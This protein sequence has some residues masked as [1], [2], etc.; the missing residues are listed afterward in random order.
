MKVSIR[1][2][3]SA[4]LIVAACAPAT[5]NAQTT[6][7][8][9]QRVVRSAT[10]SNVAMPHDTTQRRTDR[11]RQ[12]RT[13]AEAL[14]SQPDQSRKAVKLLEQSAQLRAADDPEVYTC[15]VYAARIQ[16]TLGEFT[17]AR[18]NLQTAANHALGRGAI[19][20]AAHAYID[21]AHLANKERQPRVA[22][23]MAQKARLLAGSPQLTTQQREQIAVRIR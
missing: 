18:L 11:A 2:S 9:P 23:D 16:T 19:V 20:D 15:L 3:A 8:E 22:R 14:F 12:L 6:A 7:Q 13:E 10:A 1:M 5:G 21:A 4:F 17:A